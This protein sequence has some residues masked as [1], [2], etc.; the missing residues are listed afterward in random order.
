MSKCWCSI[1]LLS[2]LLSVV[3]AQTDSVSDFAIKIAT[4]VEENEVEVSAECGSAFL[5]Y[6]HGLGKGEHWALKSK[7]I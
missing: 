3:V 6:S 5:E 7:F 1:S 2:S 4:A